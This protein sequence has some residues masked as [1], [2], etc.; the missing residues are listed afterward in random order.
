MEM[1]IVSRTGDTTRAATVADG[2]LEGY[3]VE[4]GGNGGGLAGNIYKGVV[5]SLLPSAQGCFIDIGLEKNS[6]LY[7]RDA[8]TLT[9][10]H[11]ARPIDTLLRVGMKAVVQVTRGASGSKGARVTAKLSLAGELAVLLPGGGAGCGEGGG[12]G[13]A[14][15]GACVA[16]SGKIKGAGERARL[17]TAAK[18]ALPKEGFSAIV[19]TEAEGAGRELLAADIAGLL[20]EWG[21]IMRAEREAPIPSLIYERPGLLAR[22]AS[23]AS[24]SAVSR[25]VS[26][27]DRILNELV[28][29]AADGAKRKFELY[30]EPYPVFAFYGIQS[31]VDGIA[32]RKVGLKCGARIVIDR[33]EALT[34]VDVDSAGLREGRA[35]AEAILRANIEAVVETARQLRFRD[36]GG[37]V[38]I[39]AIRM[40]DQAHYGAVIAALEA[41][42]AKDER[43]AAV[44]G[45]TRLGLIELSRAHWH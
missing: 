45:V 1:I 30:G 19:R 34:A 36:I 15:D 20:D 22:V 21:R 43:R 6:I 26:D 4:R 28:A 10:G 27:D 33:T 38:V 29:R 40:R 35:P 24:K 18:N 12:A 7:A 44:A 17:A 41:E 37:I 13:G 16:V 32:S 2:R 11:A 23:R 14:S 31:D 9:A 25:V 3:A 5:T 39:D 42:L 8:A